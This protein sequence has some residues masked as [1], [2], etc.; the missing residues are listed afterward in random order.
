MKNHSISFI[1]NKLSFVE[2]G[3]IQKEDKKLIIE[4][5]YAGICGTDL[6]I[7]NGLRPDT[8]NVLGH[9]AIGRVVTS[10]YKKFKIGQY[11]IF[12]PVDPRNQNSILGHSY[13]GIFQKYFVVN[14]KRIESVVTLNRSFEDLI[15]GVLVE[16]L[17]TVI[18]GFSLISKKKKPRSVVVVGAGPIGLLNF[19][20]CKKN[21]CEEVYLINKSADKLQWVFENGLSEK[22]YLIKNSHNLP[23]KLNKLTS[24]KG[25]DAILMCVPRSDGIKELNKA[26]KYIKNEG[27]INIVGGVS[28]GD[29]IKGSNFD[30]NSIRKA[31]VCGNPSGGEH[32]HL[33]VNGKNV[34]FTGHRGTSRKHIGKAINELRRTDSYL[35][36][37]T[38]EFNPKQA[39]RVLKRISGK[40]VRKIDGNLYIKG[41]IR[42]R[43]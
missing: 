3:I 39:T 18:Y 30:L 14:D 19:I 17:A 13:D 31:N 1:N 11:V 27:V 28:D 22:K 35:K 20:Y 33:I 8:A 7:I 34:V 40:R 16:P 10:N 37:I 2:N 32:K 43:K 29:H 6:Q 21:V 41:V 12:N 4:I 15:S 42:F 24:N 36:I 25:V 9:E 5:L 38:H 26:I 23:N